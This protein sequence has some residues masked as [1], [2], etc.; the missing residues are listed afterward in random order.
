MMWWEK[1]RIFWSNQFI[2]VSPMFITIGANV[3]AAAIV[4]SLLSQRK[5][6]GLSLATNL[7]GLHDRDSINFLQRAEEKPHLVVLQIKL[8]IEN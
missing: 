7:H 3:V 6:D 4:V 2:L 8:L 1:E 5:T